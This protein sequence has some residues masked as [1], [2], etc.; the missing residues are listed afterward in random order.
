[1]IRNCK[2]LKISLPNLLLNNFAPSDVLQ[3][4]FSRPPTCP[5]H[6]INNSLCCSKIGR[7]LGGV[8]SDPSASQLQKES[9]TEQTGVLEKLYSGTSKR[10][11]AGSDKDFPEITSGVNEYDP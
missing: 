6:W 1:M 8:G 5:T 3:K 9:L 2:T 7:S 4:F 10:T 11:A